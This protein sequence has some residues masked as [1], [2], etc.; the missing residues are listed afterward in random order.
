LDRGDLTAARQKYEQALTL[1]RQVGFR[2]GAASALNNLGIVLKREGA[3]DAAV[4]AYEESAALRREIGDRYGLATALNNLANAL[5]EKG[6]LARAQGLYLESIDIARQTGDQRALARALLNLGVVFRYQLKLAEAKRTQQESLAIRR[7][8]SPPAA[9]EALVNLGEVHALE[10]D[11]PAAR[12]AFE[13]A[14]RIF[15]AAQVKRPLSYSLAGLGSVARL[16]GRPEAEPRL[17]EAIR[18]QFEAQ[19]NNAAALTRIQLAQLHLDRGQSEQAR[20]LAEKA[21]AQLR[22]Q[23]SDQSEA[24]ALSVLSL[25]QGALGER[26]AARASAERAVE[27]TRNSEYRENRLL[28][29]AAAARDHPEELEALL[30]EATQLGLIGYQFQIRY[31]LADL[32]GSQTRFEALRQDA[33]AKGFHAIAALSAKK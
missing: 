24:L 11:L 19:E 23:Q 5:L 31:L 14:I 25:A 9:G 33:A 1:S 2:L 28:A 30:A 15:K 13:E 16:E 29:R 7:E 12:A 6:E 22:A 26:K 8:I 4:K 21:A 3:F 20:D 32:S 27:L 18:L 10:G 17:R